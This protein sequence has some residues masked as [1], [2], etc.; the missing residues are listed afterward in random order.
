MNKLNHLSTD[1]GPE[2][3]ILLP[4]DACKQIAALPNLNSPEV[5]AAG[6]SWGQPKGE[7]EVQPT[8]FRG[9]MLY[10]LR[11]L[12]TYVS[13]RTTPTPQGRHVLACINFVGAS[14]S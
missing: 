14:E 13:Q 7:T 10:F 9:L 1:S 11:L 12:P 5:T 4:S 8:S 3:N 6:A 2:F